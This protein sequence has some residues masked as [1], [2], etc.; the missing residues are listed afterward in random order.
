MF[1]TIKLLELKEKL[2]EEVRGL[3][4]EREAREAENDPHAKRRPRPCGLTIHTSIG[5][6]FQCRYCY[7]YDMGFPAKASPYP[8][9][10]IQVVYALLSNKYFIPSLH[11]TYLAIG[12]VSEPFHPL[13]KERTIEY[14]RAFYTYLGNPV[15]FSTKAYISRDDAARIADASRGLISPLVSVVTLSKWSELE[16]YAPRPELRFE[17]I[18]NLREAGLKPFLFLRPIIPG[19]TERE[20]KEIVDK[21]LEYGAVGVVA[22]GLR[23]TKGIIKNL[24]ESGVDIREVLKRVD[25]P[26]EKMK[27]GVQY[28]VYTGDIKS[29]IQKYALKRGLLFFPSACMANLYTHGMR[30]WKMGLYGVELSGMRRP[31]VEEATSLLERLGFKAS[32]VTLGTAAIV[33]EGKCVN[34]D[35]TFVSE[36]LLHEFKMCP[37]LRL[38]RG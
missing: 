7:I 15:Q 10:G 1:N 22:G 19:V 32:S 6:F 30:C 21:A 37:R 8:L 28:D 31:S 16:P 20:Y 36:V 11:G 33:A 5:C 27:N 13:V 25:V 26:V 18:K 17:T 29:S 38:S 4:S 35:P 23:V 24:K 14:V 3:L 2:R 34:C 9:S 12:S